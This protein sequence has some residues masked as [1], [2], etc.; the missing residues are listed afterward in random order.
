MEHF[1]GEQEIF[2]E[3]AR[4]TGGDAE[5]FQVIA[6]IEEAAAAEITIAAMNIGSDGDRITNREAGDGFSGFDDNSRSFVTGGKTRDASRRAFFPA[7]KIGAADTA[8]FDLQQ[9]AIF[10]DNGCGD[11]FN[12]NGF[13][14][15]LK[16]RISQ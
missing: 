2:R 15:P 10:R 8:G 5:Q 1:T 11:F 3:S 16:K 4:V 7:P 14:E 13:G 6:E 9:Q 12:Y